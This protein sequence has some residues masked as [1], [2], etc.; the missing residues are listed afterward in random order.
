MGLLI[1]ALLV[2]ATVTHETCFLGN[3]RALV[4]HGAPGTADGSAHGVV[5]LAFLGSCEL[6]NGSENTRLSPM[7]IGTTRVQLCSV[8]DG[9][10]IAGTPSIVVRGVF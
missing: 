1:H 9:V 3:R 8:I 10:E 4:A 2:I 7:M 6:A 5:R